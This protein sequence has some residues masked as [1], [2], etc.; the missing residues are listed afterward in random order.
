MDVQV[1]L[2]K[3]KKQ[4]AELT[5]RNEALEVAETKKLE[6]AYQKFTDDVLEVV[7]EGDDMEEDFNHLVK[8]IEDDDLFID[9]IEMNNPTS[10]VLGFNF[11]EVVTKLANKHFLGS[12]PTED[13]ERFKEHL[14]DAV[15][16]PFLK[17]LLDTN[18][19]TGIIANV[20]TKV[21]SFVKRVKV[22]NRQVVSIEKAFD[23][24]KLASFIDEMEKY[25][26][27][28][29][30]LVKAGDDYK[31]NKRTLTSSK[32]A[33]ET[34]LN[35][36]HK[37]FL[38]VLKIKEKKGA[39][40]WKEVFA[41]FNPAKIKGKAKLEAV[42]AEEDNK[43]AH[44][45]ALKFPALKERISKFKQEYYQVLITFFQ[46]NLKALEAARL[47]SFKNNNIAKLEKKVAKQIK[48]LEK[49]I[50][51]AKAAVATS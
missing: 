31:A 51:T 43:K 50:Q 29:A 7:S 20:I 19:I 41:K 46:Q 27:F 30:L 47:L 48:N 18:P 4:V 11:G 13:H 32:L 2:K 1:E 33:L 22:K 34:H 5:T 12:L 17:I 24:V 36:Y 26:G 28:Y 8:K 21:T 9:L 16:P 23:N 6:A 37:D 25:L 35:D 15:K 39:K 49:E 45:I 44:Q 3:L 10:N 14:K 40:L 38:T 42:L